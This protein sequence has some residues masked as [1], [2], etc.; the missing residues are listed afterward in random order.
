MTSTINTI[1]TPLAFNITVN[2]YLVRTDKGYILIDTGMSNQRSAIKQELEQAGCQPG[3]LKLIILTHGDSDHCGNAAYLRQKFGARIAMQYDDSGMV[4][5]GDM[6]WNRQNSHSLISILFGLFFS[7]S[8]SDR[9]KPDLY[10]EDRARLFEY[11]FDAEVI[12]IPGHSKGSLGIFTA[13]GDFFCGDLL[14]NLNQPEFWFIDDSGAA[15]ASIKKLKSLKINLV[16]PGHGK[17][18]LMEQFN[19]EKT[20]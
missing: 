14:A 18:F 6:S 19:Q 2:C 16:Y 12:H 11:G 1:T 10:V 17:P 8:K 7:L 15:N 3:T 20:R 4:E 9:F 13:S 5:R